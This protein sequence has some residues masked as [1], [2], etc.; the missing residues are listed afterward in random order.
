MEEVP[1]GTRELDLS[2]KGLTAL[3]ES[4]DSLT[5][6]TK[7]RV[8]RNELAELPAAVG[9]LTAL[10]E[11]PLRPHRRTHVMGARAF[12]RKNPVRRFI[13]NVLLL[14]M[15]PQAVESAVIEVTAGGN[16]KEPTYLFTEEHGIAA[17]LTA[18]NGTIK[19]SGDLETGS[20]V[21]LVDLAARLV[22][23]E[24]KLAAAEES[25]QWF[26][27]NTGPFYVEFD[28]RP[29]ETYMAFGGKYGTYAASAGTIRYFYRGSQYDGYISAASSQPIWHD[30]G[31]VKGI[32]F[33]IGISNNNAKVGL[34]TSSQFEALKALNTAHDSLFTAVNPKFQI[35]TEK[36]VHGN[37]DLFAYPTETNKGSLYPYSGFTEYIT[38]EM[39]WRS[40][41]ATSGCNVVNGW[42]TCTTVGR[43]IQMNVID[44]TKVTV[45]GTVMDVSPS[46][47]PLYPCLTL[48]ARNKQRLD[49]N[50]WEFRFRTK[51]DDGATCGMN[52]C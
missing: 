35:Y 51:G 30:R 9:S 15:I 48:N 29:H 8:S 24:A 32:S 22:A 31:I 45:G 17:N 18:R 20:G 2:G 41:D 26:D 52:A 50:L 36:D 14:M 4:I 34:C 27:K 3:S 39:W 21:S 13:G 11:L 12:H 47:W 42:E 37:L 7:L 46:D 33:V 43:R 16:V 1:L 19:A 49:P 38:P 5:A 25:I 23:V 40:K 44:A 10:T 28:V 6:L